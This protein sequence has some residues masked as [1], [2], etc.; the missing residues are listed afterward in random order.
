[1][2]SQPE[3]LGSVRI[4]V[5]VRSN[6]FLI[7]DRPDAVKEECSACG[8]AVWFDPNQVIPEGITDEQIWCNDCAINNPVVG[9]TLSQNIVPAM[10][11]YRLYGKTHTWHVDPRDDTMDRGSD[12][13]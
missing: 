10:T 13:S 1:M 12:S 8:V 3:S 4:C 9:P 2:A 6:P 5:P 7:L 11:A